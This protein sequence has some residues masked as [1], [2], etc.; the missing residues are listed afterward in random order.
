M[1]PLQYL[2]KLVSYIKNGPTVT[3]NI[4]AA[5]TYLAPNERLK[6]KRII[7]TGG[8]RGLGYAMAKKFISEGANVLIAGRDE[9]TLIEKSKELNCKYL[10]LDVQKTEYFSEFI[11]NAAELM[12]GIDCIVN[13]AGIS[14]HEGNIRNVSREQFDAQIETNLRGA[15]FLSQK[16]IE[17]FEQAGLTNGNILFTSSERGSFVDDLPY[18]LTKTAINSLIQGLA[19]RVIKKGIRVNG[20]APGVTTSDMTGFKANE[21]LYVPWNANERVY[22]PE[23][24]AEVAC[25]LLSDASKC[26]SGQIIV[27]NES[28]SVN[29]HWK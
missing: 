22:L 4:T 18:G 28:K 1:N 21:N 12:S 26:I 24:V 11:A 23:E 17:Y 29:A 16:Y 9:Q 20:V 15:Y 13:N 14:L 6:G 25:F 19:Y 7:I 2:R 8:G 5:I 3:K 10:I 27:C